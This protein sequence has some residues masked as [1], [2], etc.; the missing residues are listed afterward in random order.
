M[1]IL[2]KHR[3]MFH[4]FV[5]YCCAR[6]LAA[7]FLNISPEPIRRSRILRLYWPDVLF[8]CRAAPIA[9]G[10]QTMENDVKP[11]KDGSHDNK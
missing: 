6:F 1:A 8:F 9:V 2:C 7:C 3:V 5:N 4:Q 10:T 11:S